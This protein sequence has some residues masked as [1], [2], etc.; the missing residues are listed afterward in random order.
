MVFPSVRD[1][2]AGVVF[3]ALATGAVP[4]VADFG[5]PGDIVHPEVGYK[6]P[7]TNEND[8][9]AQM[10][11]ILTELAHDRDY[12]AITKAGNDLCAGTPNLGREGA[13]HY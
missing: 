7:L 3:E 12:R 11:K 8:F 13:G 2:G 10:E 9:V 4:V 5:G 1:F 6:V